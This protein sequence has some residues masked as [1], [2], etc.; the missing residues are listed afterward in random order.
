MLAERLAGLKRMLVSI[1]THKQPVLLAS[2]VEWPDML[3]QKPRPSVYNPS[4]HSF[5][6]LVY[7]DSGTCAIVLGDR[8][9]KLKE[10]DICVIGVEEE[11]Y[12]TPIVP[13]IGYC[14]YWFKILHNKLTVHVTRY[15]PDQGLDWLQE[16]HSI[17]LD[18]NLEVLFQAMMDEAHT[19][20]EFSGNIV[21][22]YLLVFAGMMCQRLCDTGWAEEVLQTAGNDAIIS[23]AIGYI[24]RNYAGRECTV[25]NLA[26]YVMLNPNYLSAY[27]KRKTGY[28]PYQ[29][30]MRIRMEKARQLLIKEAWGIKEISEAVGYS[31]PY[32][33]SSI[34]KRY[35]HLSPTEYRRRLQVG[36][37]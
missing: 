31:S 22:G 36:L 28:T 21:R 23:K 8:A 7:V 32:H 14:A 4:V 34:F 10:G 9:Y 15:N 5:Y 12:E 37:I 6:E 33:F 19:A 20:S 16:E 3:P 18:S 11:H 13:E 17:W 27:C 2:G 35:Y 24:A 30:I 1:E 25:A 26:S 29:L